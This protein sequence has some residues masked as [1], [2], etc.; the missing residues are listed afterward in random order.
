[1]GKTNVEKD[2]AKAFFGS[3]PL[4]IAEVFGQSEKKKKNDGMVRAG[5]EVDE[6]STQ[7]SQKSSCC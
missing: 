4:V 1:M 3:L 2:C 6:E 7:G 5:C